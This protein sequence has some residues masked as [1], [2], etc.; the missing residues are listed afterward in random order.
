MTGARFAG[1]VALAAA[2][3]SLIMLAVAVGVGQGQSTTAPS[4]LT[5]E[6]PL[7]KQKL[8]AEPGSTV[9][10]R[11]GRSSESGGPGGG[12]SM[13]WLLLLAPVA[14]VVFLVWLVA[15]TRS[16]PPTAY[17]YAL[18]NDQRRRRRVPASVIRLLTP[19][20]YSHHRDAYVLRGIGNRTVSVL[21]LRAADAEPR[22]TRPAARVAPGAAPLGVRGEELPARL[23]RAP[24]ATNG[25]APERNA[26]PKPKPKPAKPK[27]T[28]KQQTTKPAK[29]NKPVKASKNG[30]G[31]KAS[32]SPKSAKSKGKPA[33]DS[34]PS[35]A[36]TGRFKRDEPKDAR[37]KQPPTKTRK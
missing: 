4:Q 22:A 14:V 10:D 30:K 3:L 5:Q 8:A 2:A 35:P 36:P 18:G 28:K 27:A 32:A 11:P 13:L 9:A 34:A 23:L 33:R 12:G 20:S 29:A 31:R 24:P 19:F 26:T 21:K 17:G 6:Y 1:R 25:A 7:G 16:G 15:Y 37:G